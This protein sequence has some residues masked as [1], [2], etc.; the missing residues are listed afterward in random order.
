MKH[1]LLTIRPILGW[2]AVAV[3]LAFPVLTLSGAVDI[4]LRL[5]EI[6]GESQDK[7]HKGEIEVLAWNWGMSNSGTTHLG[8]TGGE[9]KSSVK[10]LSITKWIDKATPTIMFH[11]LTG[12]RIPSALLTIRKAGGIT[13]VEFLKIDFK[14]I[15][16]TS[17]NTGGS[18]GE[19]RL[20]ET[21]TLNFANFKLTYTPQAPD[22]T[23]LPAI[24]L[25]WDIVAKKG[26]VK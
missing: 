19:D 13:P 2:L 9:G 17:A 6:A 20:T 14:D 4:F 18:G 12:E 15:I 21:I 1:I 3:V 10:D 8:L 22:G 24:S 5:G 7:V 16:V 26:E 11:A 25:D 23:T